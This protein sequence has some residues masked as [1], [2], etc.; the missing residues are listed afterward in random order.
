[1]VPARRSTCYFIVSDYCAIESPFLLNQE[2]V[3]QVDE[4][5]FCD[6]AFLFT[7][8][9]HFIYEYAAH[10]H[11]NP[12]KHF[13]F[14]H[15]LCLWNKYDVHQKTNRI[16]LTVCDNLTIPELRFSHCPLTPKGHTIIEN[17]LL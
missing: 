11:C 3:Q 17:R 8:I 13:Y 1:M 6:R 12:V 9:G 5:K 14:R 10:P 4:I 2:Y 15:F 16:K 7:C